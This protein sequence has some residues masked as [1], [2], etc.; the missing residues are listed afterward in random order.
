[1]QNGIDQAW[2]YIRDQAANLR[3]TIQEWNLRHR[4]RGLWR[5][6]KRGRHGFGTVGVLVLTWALPLVWAASGEA[7]MRWMGTVLQILGVGTVAWGL[8]QTRALSDYPPIWTALIDWFKELPDALSGPKTIKASLSATVP[9]GFSADAR[10]RKSIPDDAS[11]EERVAFLEEQYEALREKQRE[12]K[13]QLEERAED[14][15]EQI[16]DEET[17]REKA[18]ERLR[19][20]IEEVSIGGL[21]LEMVGLVWLV[22]G[23]M[24]ASLPQELAAVLSWL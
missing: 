20:T 7:H 3:T 6:V 1:M 10:V 9:V 12:T 16:E 5:H 18:D 24:C 23:I 11:L 19:D 17:V 2:D 15:E 22:V 21:H 4:A 13:R 14:L 8:S